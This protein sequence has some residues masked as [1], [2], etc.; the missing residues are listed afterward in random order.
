MDPD[1]LVMQSYLSNNRMFILVFYYQKII[2]IYYILLMLSN[3]IFCFKQLFS[4]KFFTS[5]LLKLLFVVCV[6]FEIFNHSDRHLLFH[7]CWFWSSYVGRPH[8][9]YSVQHIVCLLS[10]LTFRIDDTPERSYIL[11]IQSK[12]Q[13]DQT[14]YGILDF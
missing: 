3:D 14:W 9:T 8:I 1:P 2:L 13:F 12:C 7:L 4:N 6:V 10:V 11:I 5:Y